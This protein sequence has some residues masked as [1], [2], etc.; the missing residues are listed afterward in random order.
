MTQRPTLLITRPAAE[1]E[2]TAIAA[3]AAGFDPLAA[4]LLVIEQLAFD[5]PAHLPPALLFTSARTPALVAARFPQL[6]HLPVY[7]VGEHCAA[8]TTAA[9]FAVRATGTT[10][11][12]AILA[13]AHAAGETRLLHPGGEQKAA[14]HVPAGMSIEHRTAYTMVAVSAL[15]D[16]AVAALAGGAAALLMSPRT[17]ALFARLVD[18]GGLQRQ[19]VALAVISAAAAQAAGPGWKKISVAAQPNL[20]ASLAAARLLWHKGCNA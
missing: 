1:Q 9:G 3:R 10:D 2:R 18:A 6:R 19:R 15:P 13:I 8:A 20:A 5:L 7:A 14:Y 17:A 16:A 11:G 12:S 4:P